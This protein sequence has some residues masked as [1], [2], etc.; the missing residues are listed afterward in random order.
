MCR[1]PDRFGYSKIFG[2]CLSYPEDVRRHEETPLFLKGLLEC[3]AMHREVVL[4][5]EPDKRTGAADF[6]AGH[7]PQLGETPMPWILSI[8]QRYIIDSF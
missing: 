5:S 4:S 8:A 7:V 1:E 6:C 3:K 2:N